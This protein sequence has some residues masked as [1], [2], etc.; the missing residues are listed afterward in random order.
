MTT[1]AGP[2]CNCWRAISV[3]DFNPRLSDGAHC[4]ACPEYKRLPNVLDR[5]AARTVHSKNCEPCRD[6]D[7]ESSVETLRQA[8]DMEQ[9]EA[10][11]EAVVEA[12]P[13]ILL[14]LSRA[15]RALASIDQGGTGLLFNGARFK[16]IQIF[17]GR[18][19]HAAFEAIEAI[20]EGDFRNYKAVEQVIAQARLNK[21]E[22][23]ALAAATA[24]RDAAREGREGM[25]AEEVVA[26]PD[27]AI[28]L[29]EIQ[30]LDKSDGRPKAR[31]NHARLVARRG[32]ETAS[33]FLRGLVRYVGT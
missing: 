3:V 22:P 19:C 27:A 33:G 24:W 18:E 28:A 9:L 21:N 16:G 23:E 5:I 11:A 32:H 2:L 25:A 31:V 17:A 8:R 15:S 12:R 7:T 29:A 20:F 14:A 13:G 4:P 1:P 30:F 6:P 10:W 26:L